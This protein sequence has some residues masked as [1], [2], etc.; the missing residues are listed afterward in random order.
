MVKCTSYSPSCLTV[1]YASSV[2]YPDHSTT[3]S[4]YILLINLRPNYFKYNHAQFS[5]VYTFIYIPSL[6]LLITTNLRSDS[7]NFNSNRLD[8]WSGYPTDSANYQSNRRYSKTD[9]RLHSVSVRFVTLHFTSTPF[10][11]N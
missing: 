7:T 5:R 11:N 4:S 9:Y 6:L 8:L 3:Y 2:V 10:I 1:R